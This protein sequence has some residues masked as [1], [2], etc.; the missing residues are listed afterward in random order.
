MSNTTISLI[1][2]LSCFFVFNA[3]AENWVLVN[4]NNGLNYYHDK[5][6]LLYPYA[7]I[8][9]TFVLKEKIRAKNKDGIN[10]KIENQK[11]AGFPTKDYENFKESILL[12]KYDC[13]FRKSLIVWLVDY[14]QNGD[15]LGQYSIYPEA[16]MKGAMSDDVIK[17][18]Q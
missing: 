8:K 12:V 5:D 2:L 14:D 18:C 11:Q 6:S 15:V 17:L 3:N 7:P 13:E 16:P 10:S 4:T 9:S 1:I